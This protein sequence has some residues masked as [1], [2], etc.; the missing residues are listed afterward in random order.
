M[1]EAPSS[2]NGDL[3]TGDTIAHFVLKRQLGRGGMGVVYEAEDRKLRRRVA[4]K[5]LP[6]EFVGHDERR[7]RF[8]REARSAAAVTHSN[9]AVIYEAGQDEGRIYIAMEYI[10][11]ESLRQR[12]KRDLGTEEALRI[13][14][15]ILR[16]LG[17]AHEA[18][19]VHRDLKP[20]NVMLDSSGEVKVLDFG[21]AK[22]HEPPSAKDGSVE[23]A[24]EEAST[25][26]ADLTHLG[27]PMGTPGYMSPEQAAGEQVDQRTDIFAFGVVLYE[28]L[29]GERPFRGK[30]PMEVV[31][32]TL[33]EEPEAPSSCRDG[34]T[35][36]FDALVQRCLAKKPEDRY[37]SIAEVS[38]ALEQLM[39]RPSEPPVEAKEDRPAPPSAA[40][41]LRSPTHSRSYLRWVALAATLLIAVAIAVFLRWGDDD[42]DCPTVSSDA[43]VQ[44]EFCRGL[45]AYL[46]T[47]VAN[48]E[49]SFEVAAE[50]APD[51][52][53]PHLGLSL[54][55]GLKKHSSSAS[56][57]L[58]KAIELGAAANERDQQL[59][60]I[61]SLIDK[62]PIDETIAAWGAFKEEHPSYFLAFQIIA[63]RLSYKESTEAGL[64]RFDDAL[65][66][67][68]GHAITYFTK[69]NVYLG[70]ARL[71]EAATT[72]AA[73][74]ERRPRS[75]WLL[76]Q[77]GMVDMATGDYG[78]AQDRLV[79]SIKHHGPVQARVYYAVALLNDGQEDK[80]KL[81]VAELS[82]LKNENDRLTFLCSH[83]LALQ[84]RGRSA[85]A[86]ALLSDAIAVAT[87]A[88]KVLA[89][90]AFRCIAWSIWFD[91]ALGRF[92]VADDKMKK[93][94]EAILLG[95]PKADYEGAMELRNMLSAV[96]DAERGRLESAEKSFAA[97]RSPKKKAFVSLRMALARASAQRPDVPDVAAE[98]WLVM[99]KAERTYTRARTLEAAGDVH[100]AVDEFAKLEKLVDRCAN[101]TRSRDYPCAAY[102]AAGLV[103]LAEL[104]VERGNGAHA[105]A[106]IAGFDRLWPRPDAGL[107]LVERARA[108]RETF[109]P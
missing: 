42:T 57:E 40:E 33:R 85:D 72:I 54:V 49:R 86:D 48:A 103:R 91:E 100:Q 102:V 55:H 98:K 28:M 12:M 29:A 27:R 68:D 47:D 83:A 108:V 81:E 10:D 70:D 88:G 23:E 1:G 9:I 2:Q 22:I 58:E 97:L 26:T 106:A 66:I 107:A 63:Y 61:L 78:A 79:E 62:R 89:G 18:G 60:R 41:T 84:R 105:V 92:N 65:A 25:A 87:K 44:S 99:T 13:A 11:G 14:K 17:K 15:A 50:R 73:G 104:E 109:E 71:D 5:V 31:V 82:R 76:M 90:D 36:A 21:L 19:I 101:T 51:S 43:E 16:G 77:R 95:L 94:G 38:E 64:S 20:D 7:M 74:L 24:V 80:R 67:N 34:L 56:H 32:A 75:P 37:A 8:L 39:A 96:V 30:T 4:L 46:A 53:W 93:A 59:I 52:P 3:S 35:G 6:P 69:A 45:E